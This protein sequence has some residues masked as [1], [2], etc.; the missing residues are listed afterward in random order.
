LH[1]Q[2]GFVDSAFSEKIPELGSTAC[3]LRVGGK[4]TFRLFFASGLRL[5]DAGILKNG[6]LK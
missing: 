2:T 5:N 1:S 4:P 6:N 3:A